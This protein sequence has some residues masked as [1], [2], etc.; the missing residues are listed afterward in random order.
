MLNA[1]DLVL[2]FALNWVFWRG[3]TVKSAGIRLCDCIFDALKSLEQVAL[4][5]M[6][7]GQQKPQIIDISVGV[8]RTL[9]WPSCCCTQPCP[10]AY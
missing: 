10:L 2:F 7:A 8:A 4:L 5:V 3:K 1:N 6:P 9:K